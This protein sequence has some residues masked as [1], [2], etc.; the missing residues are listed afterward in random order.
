MSRP[1]SLLMDIPVSPPALPDFSFDS[2]Q[3]PGVE[4]LRC[5]GEIDAAAAE[6][7]SAL[8]GSALLSGDVVVDASCITFIDC[9][10]LTP[11]LRGYATAAA[12][13]RRFTLAAPSASVLRLLDHTGL[14]HR[15]ELPSCVATAAKPTLQTPVVL[16]RH[17]AATP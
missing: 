4:V 11:L 8:I 16:D 3:F 5:A 14:L 10:G 7:L 17:A 6:P 2:Q 9:S 15:L 12:L 1:K 13:G